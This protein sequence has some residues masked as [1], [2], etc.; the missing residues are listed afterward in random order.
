SRKEAGAGSL[1]SATM[2]ASSWWCSCCFNGST[3]GGQAEG[4]G[5]IW[6]W[7]MGADSGSIPVGMYATVRISPLG[8]K[9][10]AILRIRAD[11]TGSRPRPGATKESYS[12]ITKGLVLTPG[13]QPNGL[14]PNQI[15]TAPDKTL[16][17]RGG[18]SDGPTSLASG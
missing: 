17:G 10:I 3:V 13:L 11:R 15:A 5:L 2:I 12:R 7:L 18:P 8:H 6:R 9:F 4:G 1:R 16:S 14:H